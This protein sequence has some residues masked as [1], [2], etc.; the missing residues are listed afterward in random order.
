M[1][2]EAERASG[3]GQQARPGLQPPDGVIQTRAEEV[4]CIAVDKVFDFCFQEQVCT[5]TVP[6]SLPMNTPVG[7]TLQPANATCQV[8]GEPKPLDGG[9]AQVT[10]QITVPATVQIG[11]QAPMPVNFV[12]FRSLQLNMPPGSTIDCDVSGSCFCALVDANGDEFSDELFCQANLCI[13]L[14][15]TARVKLL[16]PALGLCTPVLCRDAGPVC[17]PELSESP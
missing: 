15:T 11:T 17:P 13:V 6:V 4:V 5:R 9:L 7:C 12:C 3:G 2:S 10:L 8:V 1:P 14:E 16:V